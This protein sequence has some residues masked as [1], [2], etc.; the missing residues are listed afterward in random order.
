[1]YY[2][3][4]LNLIGI[5]QAGLSFQLNFQSNFLNVVIRM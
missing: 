3:K 2:N 1:M 5:L 4:S